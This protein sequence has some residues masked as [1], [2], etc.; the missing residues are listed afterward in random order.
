MVPAPMEYMLEY[1]TPSDP[2]A[3]QTPRSTAIF[4]IFWSSLF[5]EK[6]SLCEFFRSCYKENVALIVVFF[7]HTTNMY[8]RSIYK[9][10]T[11]LSVKNN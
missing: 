11:S 9:Q 7:Y 5:V 10:D 3:Y 4:D 1:E 8:L 2:S 6:Y